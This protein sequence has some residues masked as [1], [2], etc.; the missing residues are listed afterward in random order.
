MMAHM[1]MI[2]KSLFKHNNNCDP[3]CPNYIFGKATHKAWK[4]KSM[5]KQIKPAGKTGKYVFVDSLKSSTKGIIA[6]MKGN[7]M[8][9][10]YTVAMVYLDQ[11]QAYPLCTCK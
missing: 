7:L 10:R 6:Q 8:K 9:D 3:T 5:P 11:F 2:T 1:G 4:S